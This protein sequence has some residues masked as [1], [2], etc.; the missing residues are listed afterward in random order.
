M[1]INK[2]RKFT[3]V[4]NN[5]CYGP[6]P[7]EE[8]IIEQRLTITTAG[9]VYLRKYAFSGNV[10][11]SK[12]ISIDKDDAYDI[13]ND[14]VD[15][16]NDNPIIMFATD[17]GTWE[18]AF[19][20]EDKTK[21]VF[22]GSLGYDYHEWLGRFSCNLRKY[23]KEWDLFVFDG[24]YEQ[25]EEDGIMFCSCEFSRGSP[26]YYYISE[27]P[28]LKEGDK[29]LVPVGDNGNTAIVE[30]V[31]IDYFDEDNVPMP[32]ERVKKIVSKVVDDK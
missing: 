5:L 24:N 30:I 12:I 3:L 28:I 32:L 29:V 27:D 16:F 9:K 7:E 14:L 18:L 26:T 13:V 17:I 23:L 15:Y 25:E 22:N 20:G 4:S 1:F 21:H 8:E 10:V 11:E 19:F 6:A 2:I 31:Q